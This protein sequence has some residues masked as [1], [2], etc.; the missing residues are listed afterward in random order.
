[1]YRSCTY[2]FR[3]TPSYLGFVIPNKW[4]IFSFLMLL[5]KLLYFIFVINKNTTDF[6][7]G[8]VAK[9][10]FNS[11]SLLVDLGFFLM[12]NHVC[13]SL[14]FI[15][16]IFPLARISNTMINRNGHTRNLFLFLSQWKCSQ[17][18][19]IKYAM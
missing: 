7:Y 6:V 16:L 19:P 2:F 3:L 8:D 12:C 14:P 13:N 9:F 11:I 4:Y 18:L 10:T 5:N 17:Y 1:M 15:Y